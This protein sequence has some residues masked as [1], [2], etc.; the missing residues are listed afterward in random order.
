MK[1][2]EKYAKEIIEIAAIGD[3]VAIEKSS[4]ILKPCDK[5]EH[6]FGCLFHT[7]EQQC[8]C[9][10]NRIRWFNEE[11]VEPLVISSKDVRLL[12]CIKDGYKYIARDFNGDMFL[13]INKPEKRLRIWLSDE[14]CASIKPFDVCFPMVK[15]EDKEPW[16]IEDLMKLKLVREYE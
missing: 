6:C 3:S 12:E 8:S 11:Y 4:G 10:E 5:T 9:F 15:W 13:F 1:N 2:K 16:L 14:E 7:P